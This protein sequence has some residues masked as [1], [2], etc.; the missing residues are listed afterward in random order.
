M[1][2][3]KDDKDIDLSN[4][5]EL[6]PG[7]STKQPKTSFTTAQVKELGQALEISQL[8]RSLE[9]ISTFLEKKFIE[10]SDDLEQS[11]DKETTSHSKCKAQL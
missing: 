6:P 4:E 10:D 5:E 9:S 8:H 7:S 11:S 1:E 3:H 2:G